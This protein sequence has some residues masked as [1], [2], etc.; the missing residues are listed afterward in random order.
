VF[1]VFVCEAFAVGALGEADALAEGAVVG[2]GVG[3]V[4]GWDGVAAGYA[5]RHFR[6]GFT[7]REESEVER[8]EC[9][10]RCSEV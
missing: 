10:R 2:F 8:G 7:W 5:N 4:E 1:D 6:G 3:G 9:M